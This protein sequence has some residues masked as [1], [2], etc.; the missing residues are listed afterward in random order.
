MDHVHNGLQKAE[1][2]NNAG[3][4]SGM[5]VARIR[6]NAGYTICRRPEVRHMQRKADG[7]V[8]ARQLDDNPQH[9]VGGRHTRVIEHKKE[10]KCIFL[11]NRQRLVRQHD[12]GPDS[13]RSGGQQLVDEKK[14]I[15]FLV[16]PPPKFVSGHSWHQQA[17][18]SKESIGNSQTCTRWEAAEM[19]DARDEK[20]WEADN[21]GIGAEGKEEGVSEVGDAVLVPQSIYDQH[22]RDDSVSDCHWHVNVLEN[23][24]AFSRVV[25]AGRE[26]DVVKARVEKL[27]TGRRCPGGRSHS[28]VR[29]GAD[30]KT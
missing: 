4:A 16:L 10:E 14:T 15:E 24:V 18:G 8:A 29:S 21:E 3:V 1:T 13:A 6:I 26:Q 7:E 27:V 22:R 20:G 25:E 11:A 17:H 9:E 2:S 12:R 28:T 30:Q 19:H 5:T 23:Q